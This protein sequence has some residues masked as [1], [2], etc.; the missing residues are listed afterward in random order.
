MSEDCLTLNIWAPASARKAPVFFWI[1]GGALSSGSGSDGLYDG[2]ALAA[3][4]DVVVVSGNYRVG[5]LGFLVVDHPDAVANCGLLD[6]VAMLEWVRHNIAAF[7]GDPGRVTVFGESAGGG[8]VLSLLA[9]PRAE[10]LFHGAIVQSGATDLVLSRDAARVVADAF[11]RNAGVDPGDLDAL[12]ALPTAAVLDAQ[13]RSAA[14][15][16]STIGLMP[17]HPTADGTVLPVAWLDAARA[18]TSRDVALLLGT[19]RDEMA[20]FDSFDPGL[21]AL[22][23]AGVRRRLDARHPDHDALLD[24]YRAVSPALAGGA[25]WSAITTDTAMWMPALRIAEAHAA[26]QPDTWMYRFDWTAADPALGACHGVDIPF[27][28]DTFD[29]D[30]WDDFVADAA[31]ARRLARAMQG[32]WA[33]F[34]RTGEPA[35]PLLPAWPCY[36]LKRRATMI[37]G[38][39]P[40]VEADPRGVVRAQWA[41]A[42]TLPA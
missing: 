27:A 26:H 37:L 14:E 9:M 33:A 39:E 21:P 29:R 20:L 17:F 12:R 3:R 31:G 23:D 22:D 15:V 16:H 4:E 42:S 8:S 41:A 34:A 10:G 11:A 24:A 7:G 6:Q 30:G 38:P 5:A 18:G 25:L 1:H 35:T 36:D 19:T 32:A 2:A 13:Q 40:H 28:F